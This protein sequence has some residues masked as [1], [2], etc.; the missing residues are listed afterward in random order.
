MSS[1]SPARGR[2]PRSRPF[3][4]A[5]TLVVLTLA[6]L[7]LLFHLLATVSEPVAD[8]LRMYPEGP[9]APLEDAELGHRPN[10]THPE[11]DARGFR[12]PAALNRAEIVA[13]GDSQTYGAGVESDEAWPR[14]LEATTGRTTYSMAYGG[15]GPVHGLV[16]LDE[17]LALEPEAIIYGIYAGNDLFD[18]Y[19]VVHVEGQRRD[20][21]APSVDLARLRALR[22]ESPLA[23]EANELFRVRT[24]VNPL[25]AFLSEHSKLYGL[26][27]A[28]RRVADRSVGGE[29]AS[30]PSLEARARA[31]GGRLVVFRSGEQG[32]VFT[33]RYRLLV[34]DLEE[35]RIREGLRLSLEALARIHER[36]AE[37]GVEFRALLIPTK[38][39]VFRHVVEASGRDLGDEYRRLVRF[40][41][42]LWKEVRDF[43]DER[44]IAFLD[45]APVLTGVLAEDPF[46]PYRISSDG[47]PNPLG[48]RVLARLVAGALAEGAPRDAATLQGSGASPPPRG[49][50]SPMDD[51]RAHERTTARTFPAARW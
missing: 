21:V 31:S 46:Q 20:L 34:L 7:E 26:L 9:H 23:E 37:H 40:E 1:S 45:A 18:S 32:T 39:Y 22:T 24:A 6:F 35:A 8:T 41:A 12:N 27:R 17:A 2:R 30:W 14:V 25:R 49:P 3:A 47:H 10:P 13:L 5:A 19:K 15:Y 11:H 50:P 33:P 28:L 36:C 29:P 44:G 51:G 42:L 48:Q 16:L 4:F 38:E 43:L